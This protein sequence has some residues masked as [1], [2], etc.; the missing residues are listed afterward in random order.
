MRS[1]L[2]SYCGP[3]T[4]TSPTICLDIATY[5]TI[6]LGRH[7]QC[8]NELSA[9]KDINELA[10]RQRHDLALRIAR[11]PWVQRRYP[12]EQFEIYTLGSLPIL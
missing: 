4:E 6:G 9:L 10:K 1:L 3:F 5:V 12:A 7:H 8:S 2:P 11:A